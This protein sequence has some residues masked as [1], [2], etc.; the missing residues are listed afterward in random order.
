MS[1]QGGRD[2]EGAVPYK[3]G[4]YEM[5][6]TEEILVGAIHESPAVFRSGLFRANT[7]RPYEL[8]ALRRAE[9][10]RTGDS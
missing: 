5:S 10:S 8:G 7:V 9:V 6:P 2:V 4:Y 3:G 1:L